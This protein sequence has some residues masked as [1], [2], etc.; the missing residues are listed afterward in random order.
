MSGIAILQVSNEIIKRCSTKICLEDIF[1]GKIKTS[2]SGL[3]DS[4]QCCEA[5]KET[6]Q[7]VSSP[8]PYSLYMID[9]ITTC[10]C[11]S[12]LCHD[13]HVCSSSYRSVDYIPSFLVSGGSW[14][15][16]ASLLKLTP[17]FSAA[18]I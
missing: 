7:R 2:M 11:H 16:A 8:G 14:I 9:L 5:W 3:Q 13:P 18:K 17:L 4:V 10:C 15:R 1:D 12:V 6:Y